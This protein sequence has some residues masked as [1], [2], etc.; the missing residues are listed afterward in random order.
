[1][2]RK[3]FFSVTCLVLLLGVGM[4]AAQTGDASPPTTT[5]PAEPS[6]VEPGTVDI[7]AADASLPDAAQPGAAQPGAVQAEDATPL[8]TPAKAA[9]DSVL[10]VGQGAT[11][12]AGTMRRGTDELGGQGARMY[13]QVLL[14]MWQRLANAL[15]SLIKAIVV[16]LLFWLAALLLS[17]LVRRLFDMTEMDEK[18]VR[19]WGLEGLL[20]REGGQQR[21]FAEVASKFVKWTVLLFGF[22]AFFQA[23]DLNMVAQPLQNV[24]DAI[25]GV[26]PNLL[27]AAVILLA[28]WVLATIVRFGLTKA[29]HLAK[30]D[31]R[32]VKYIKPAAPGEKVRVPSRTI[33][34]LAFYLVLLFGLPPFLEALNQSALVTPLT[35][36]LQEA[37]A[38]LPNIVAAILL[39]FIGKLVATIVR[40]VVVNF[41]A[42]SGLDNRVAKM[43]IADSLGSRRLSE[44]V[45]SIVY[46]FILISVVVAAV[47]TLAITAISEPVK[48]TLERLLNAVPLIFVALV[49]MAIGYAVAKGVRQLVESFLR[50]VGFD[51]FPERF[52]LHFLAP[53]EGRATLSSI[54]GTVVM[55]AILLLTAEQALATLHLDHLAVMVGALTAYLPNL[56]VGLA[57]ILVAMSLSSFAAKLLSDALGRTPQATFLVPMARYA[58][59]FLGV[60]M[61]LSQLGVAEDVVTIAVAASLF[62]LALAL[63]LAFGLGG[64]EKARELLE[65]ISDDPV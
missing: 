14:P 20:Q 4:A 5:A 43:E 39:F 16:L 62:G 29:L 34:N 41:L 2:K 35:S 27:E 54:G 57:I 26:V 52:G 30:L 65:K 33:G 7:T 28:Y 10:A 21:T 58:I 61:G 55:V 47:D 8:T 32:S 9:R 37:L 11:E 19:D 53:G 63:G 59:I 38:F 42:A 44:I 3:I 17:T 24:A 1:M 48:S 50:S 49:V 25:V 23:L 60:S 40:E 6:S 56:L 46:F 31:E 18:F 15:P 36:M 45:G 51:R 22:V 64:R 12:S 13:S